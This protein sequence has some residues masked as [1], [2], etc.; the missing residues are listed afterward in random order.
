M[1]SKY[2]TDFNLLLKLYW[3]KVSTQD[4]EREGTLDKFNWEHDLIKVSTMYTP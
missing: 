4:A 3:P 1:T 2:K